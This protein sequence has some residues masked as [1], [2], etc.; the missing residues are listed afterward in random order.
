MRWTAHR[1]PGPDPQGR[2]WYLG[3]DLSL[4]HARTC[5]GHPIRCQA[6]LQQLGPL[7]REEARRSPD[8][9]QTYVVRTDGVFVL[10]GSLH[11]HVQTASGE[12]VLAAGEAILE[13]APGGMWRILTLN[14]RSY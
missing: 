11:E 6:D 4:A 10:G 14:N 8:R 3:D 1:D 9:P 5:A 7:L 13:E 12:P 2:Y